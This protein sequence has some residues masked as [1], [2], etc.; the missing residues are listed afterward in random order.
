LYTTETS[1]PWNPV[2]TVGTNY[3][4]PLAGGGTV[5][6]NPVNLWSP[7]AFVS[8][9]ERWTSARVVRCGIRIIPS[10]NITVKAGVL[11]AGILPGVH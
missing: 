7:N 2:G 10:A 5:A 8:S 6:S 1:I 11:T 4:N 9:G 3:V